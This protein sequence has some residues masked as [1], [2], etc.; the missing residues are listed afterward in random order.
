MPEKTVEIVINFKET[1]HVRV[2]VS[3]Q[4][5]VPTICSKY[6]FDP[7]HTLLLKDNQS[8]GPATSHSLLMTRD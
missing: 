8:E 4:E 6:V 2:H 3:L 7:L 5:F 1:D